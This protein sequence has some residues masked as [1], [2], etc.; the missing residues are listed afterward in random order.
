M[1]WSFDEETKAYT[2]VVPEMDVEGKGGTSIN[3]D[4][5]LNGQQFTGAP[6]GLEIAEEVVAAKGKGKK[7]KK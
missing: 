4:I 3:V 1:A 2:F 5:A 6:L 7:G